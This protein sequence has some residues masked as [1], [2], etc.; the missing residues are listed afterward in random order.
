[1]P[2]Q[3]PN[4]QQVQPLSVADAIAQ[5]AHID[6]MKQQGQ[7]NQMR[8]PG[9]WLRFDRYWLET[10]SVQNG[11]FYLLYLCCM[12]FDTPIAPYPMQL[13]SL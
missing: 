9:L 5:W 6:Q 13:D 11:Y 12:R 2:I 4:V 10:A 3:F 8:Y 1:M 7:F